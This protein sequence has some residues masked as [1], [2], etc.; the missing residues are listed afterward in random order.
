MS[1]CV[2]ALSE[3]RPMSDGQGGGRFRCTPLGCLGLSCYLTFIGRGV[4]VTDM[5]PPYPTGW[6][7]R[8]NV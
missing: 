3:I 1:M 7:G 8:L 4:G 6:P 5:S 2:K